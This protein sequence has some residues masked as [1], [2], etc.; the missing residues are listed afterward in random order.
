MT[1]FRQLFEWRARDPTKHPPAGIRSLKLLRF[2]K[3]R[4]RLAKKQH[5]SRLKCVVQTREYLLLQIRIEIDQ[6]IPAC[7]QIYVGDRRV[8]SQIAAP[9]DDQPANLPIDP[10]QAFALKI[11]FAPLRAHPAQAFS[12]IFTAARSTQRFFVYIRRIDLDVVILN[13]RAE[14]FC[15]QDRNRIRLLSAGATGAPCA[16]GMSGFH[17]FEQ[18]WQNF[19]TQNLPRWRVTEKRR[20]IDQDSIQ[21]LSNFFGTFANV[22][23]VLGIAAHI[24]LKHPAPEPALQ[25]RALVAAEIETPLLRKLLQQ[26][27]ECD[28][29]CHLRLLPFK[30]SSERASPILPRGITKSTHPVSIAACG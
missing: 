23:G 24:E 20:D 9:E 8:L 28:V 21:E 7:Q 30:R 5:S 18:R 1:W 27:L 4:L 6:Q 29:L 2:C 19:M 25:R 17:A 15:Q 3:L 13:T 14:I 16:K 12:G 11:F 10:Q 22:F 26:I